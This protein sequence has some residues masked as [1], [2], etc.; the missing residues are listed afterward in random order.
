V[1]RAVVNFLKRIWQIVEAMSES[2]TPWDGLA[3]RL[4]Q[5]EARPEYAP[6]ARPRST[7]ADRR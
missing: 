5:L 6:A 2:S 7:P 1:I 3:E 4:K